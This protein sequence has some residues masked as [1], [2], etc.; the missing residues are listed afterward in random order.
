[1][2]KFRGK[3]MH[4]NIIIGDKILFCIRDFCGVR[5]RESRKSEKRKQGKEERSNHN[6]ENEYINFWILS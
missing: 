5:D 2:L 3:K 6:E 1:M 4:I